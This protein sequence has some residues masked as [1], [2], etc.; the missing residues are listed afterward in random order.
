[1]IRKFTFLKLLLF[2]V[3]SLAFANKREDAERRFLKASNQKDKLAQLY[4]DK[5]WKIIEEKG[6]QKAY[7]IPSQTHGIQALRSWSCGPNSAARDLEFLDVGLCHSKAKCD[8]EQEYIR[9][10]NSFPKSINMTNT[11]Q[12]ETLAGM[13]LSSLKSVGSPVEKFAAFSTLA[14]GGA[15]ASIMGDF[16]GNAGAPPSWLADHLKKLGLTRSFEAHHIMKQDFISI[17]HEIENAIQHQTPVIPL[18]V[19]DA[20]AW[21]YFVIIGYNPNSVLVLDTDGM[22]VV[23]SYEDLAVLMNPGYLK[24]DYNSTYLLA[25]L[26]GSISKLG[27]YNL[28]HISK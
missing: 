27:R 26:A 15:S 5:T 25:S 21:H 6:L 18:V 19:F 22:L 17:R 8:L 24:D 23:L 11:T 28:V 14:L 2:L 20:M 3:S 16:D 4:K 12:K 13:N 10:A 9:F 7:K 1:M